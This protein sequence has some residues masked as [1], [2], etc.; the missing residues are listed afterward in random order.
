MGRVTKIQAEKNRKPETNPIWRGIG[1]ILMF[2]LPVAS[3]FVSLITTPMVAATGLIP[4]E[5]LGQAQFP[6]WFMRVPFLAA[7]STY[8]SS[9]PN[10]WL[11]V[12]LFF[13]AMLVFTGIASLVYVSVLQTIGPPRYT[14]LDAPPST[15]KAKKYTR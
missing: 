1:C 11:G 13:I 4:L 9:I 10:L 6:A 15:Y 8:L 2:I 14:E 3:F 5:L 7:L 12:I